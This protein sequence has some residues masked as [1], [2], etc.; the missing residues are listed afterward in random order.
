MTLLVT[1]VKLE[2]VSPPPDAEVIVALLFDGPHAS[3]WSLFV[4]GNFVAGGR[5]AAAVQLGLGAELVGRA[6]EV[7]AVLVDTTGGGG[8]LT[9]AITVT[10]RAEPIAITHHGEPGTRA[11]YSI[12]V[13]FG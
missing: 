9:V 7:S 8:E 10:G 11:A 12:L 4:D 6:L 5:D 1:D 3:S 13:L 2:T